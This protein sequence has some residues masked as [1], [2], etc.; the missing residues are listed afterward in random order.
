MRYLPVIGANSQRNVRCFAGMNKFG[1]TGCW[2]ERYCNW[3]LGEKEASK[4]E[5]VKRLNALSYSEA[6][7]PHFRSR[8]ARS[9]S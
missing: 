9:G 5:P 6:T 8:A 4:V 2:R 1:R 3:V 7:S